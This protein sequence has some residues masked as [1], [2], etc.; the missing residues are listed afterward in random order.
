MGVDIMELPKT[1]GGNRYVF[2]FQD[3]L[4]KWPLAFPIPDQKSQCLA[5]LLV[6]VVVP[7]F[8]VAQA[9]LSDQGTNL[10][11]HLM[12]DI[13]SLF[14]IT[15]LNATAHHPPCDGMVEYFNRTLKSMLRKHAATFGSQWDRY[16]P[17]ALSAHCNVPHDSTQ[18]K[19][20]FLLL[21]I[22]CRTPTEAAL[23][24]PQDLEPTVV[25]NY[26]EKVILSLFTT[27]KLATKAMKSAQAR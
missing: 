8:G 21:G 16:L 7:L 14:G 26:R 20:S 2:V 6:S 9:L 25:S 12:Y 27:R 22:D 5:E 17:G 1:D 18:E 13:C 24:P 23:L 11:S 19:P 10:L 3:Y 15:K 4:M